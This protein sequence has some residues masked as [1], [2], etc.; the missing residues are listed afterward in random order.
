MTY[1]DLEMFRV[2]PWVR[3][4]R[5]LRIGSAIFAVVALS[6]SAYSVFRQAVGPGLDSL[7]IQ[8]ASLIFLILGLMLLYA[9]LMRPGARS[10]T[11]D[12]TGIRLE[13]RRGP[14]DV[15]PWSNPRFRIRGRWTNGVRDGVSRG[16]PL[17]SIYGPYGGFSESFVPQTAYN[18]LV[19]EAGRHGLR[20]IERSGR[21]GWTLYTIKRDT[22]VQLPATP[23]GMSNSG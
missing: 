10:L 21:P 19:L 16:R 22:A 14:P 23:N 20:V 5:Y 8:G 11:I 1:Y 7:D 6:L 12:E 15:R 13:F 18:D 17:W 3:F 2:V 4:I 9:F